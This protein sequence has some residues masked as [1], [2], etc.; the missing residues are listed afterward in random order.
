MCVPFI[1]T[2]FGVGSFAVHVSWPT[3]VLFVRVYDGV[4]STLHF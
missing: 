2:C 1:F 4:G 3:F